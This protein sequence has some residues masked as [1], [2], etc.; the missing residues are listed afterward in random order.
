MSIDLSRRYVLDTKQ[1]TYHVVQLGRYVLVLGLE[2]VALGLRRTELLSC[3]Q[4]ASV[5]SPRRHNRKRDDDA[6]APRAALSAP[7]PGGGGSRPSS[8]STTAEHDVVVS[9]KHHRCEVLRAASNPHL[10]H[11]LC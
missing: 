2:V 8:A 5:R 10:V 7:G 1:A 4:A 3:P 6:P 11:L 9:A